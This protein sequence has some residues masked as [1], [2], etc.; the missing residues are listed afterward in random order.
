MDGHAHCICTVLLK[1]QQSRYTGG[2]GGTVL[3][4]QT[5]SF[6]KRFQILDGQQTRRFFRYLNLI[7]NIHIQLLKILHK[8]YVN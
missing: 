1:H 7:L 6:K 4:L 2:S 5:Y 3:I 8:Y